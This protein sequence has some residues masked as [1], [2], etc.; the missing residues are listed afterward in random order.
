[1]TKTLFDPLQLHAPW[2]Q[3]LAACGARQNTALYEV[4]ESQRSYLA[5]AL[6]AHTGKQVLYVAPSE[7][8]ATRAAEDCAQLLGGA[9]ALL[10][11]PDVQF[12]RAISGRD[13]S[14]HRLQVIDRVRQGKVQVLCVSAESLLTRFMPAN[15]FDQA[16]LELKEG[17]EQDPLALIAHL[18]R[19]GY[20]RVPMVEAKGQCALLGD[21]LN[22]FPPESDEPLRIEFFDTIIDSIRSFDVL[23][24]RSTG[25]TELVRIGPATE[26][27]IAEEHRA[28]AA[29]QMQAAIQQASASLPKAQQRY[30]SL[31][32]GEQEAFSPTSLGG[33]RMLRDVEQLE[34]TGSFPNM[35]MWA[36]IVLPTTNTL[37]DLLHDPVVVIDSPDRVFQRLDERLQGFAEDLQ[38]AL[39]RE[40]AVP[41]QQHLL[42]PVDEVR[43]RLEKQPVVTMQELLRGMGGLQPALT[44][45]LQGQGSSQYQARYADL[46]LQIKQWM[47]DGWYIALL[48]SGQARAERMQR[49]LAE[50][51]VPLTLPTTSDGLL[52]LRAGQPALLSLGYSRG[53]IMPDAGL[54][55]ITD[56]DVFGSNRKKSRRRQSA[57]EKIDA[58][59][60]LS[61]GD[62]VVHEHHGVGIYRGTVRLQSEGTWRDY[63]FIQY[64]DN[65]KLYVPLDQF[66]RV[67]KYVGAGDAAPALNDLGTGDWAR[68]KKK[69]KSGLQRLAFDLVQL[70]AQRQ[71]EQGHVF[72]AQQAFEQQFSDNFEYE[73]TP[74]Q[75]QAV[76]EVLRDMERPINMDRLLCGDVGYGKTEVAM[77]AAFRAVSNSRQ[78]AFLAPTTILVQQH[79][80]TLTK[81]FEGFPV[82]MDFVSR[83]RSPRQN[84]ETLLKAA[85]GELDILIGTHR[86]L[87]KDVTF[88]NLGLLVVDEEQ[89]FGVAHKEGI[90]NLKRKVDVLTLSATPI[91]R[92]L[93]M[94]MV[95][96]RDM[97]LL[98]TPPEERLPVQTYVVEYSDAL[99]RDAILR[100]TARK[101]QVFVLH[102]RVADIDLYASRLR[103][104]VPEVRIA[105]AHGQMKE[106]ALE[107][108]MMDFVAGHYD[109]LLCTTIIENGIDIQR[110]NTLIVLDADRFGL[111]QLYQLRGRVGRGANLGYAYFTVRAGR[112]ITETAE[113]R[114]AAIKEFTEFGSGFRIA[115]RDLS[116]RGAGNMLGSEQSG[117][118]SAVGYD[119]YCKLI[120]EAVREAK[121]DFSGQRESDLETRVELHVN[122]FLPER[123]VPGQMQRMEIYKRISSI[124]TD[125]DRSDLLDEL[126]DR[127]GEPDEPVTNLMDVAYLRSLANR[128]GA[129]FVTY[130]ND[131]L[132][133]RLNTQY[134]I[135]PSLLYKAMVT[136]DPRLGMQTG[137]RNF[138]LLNLVGYEEVE[139]LKEGVCVLSHL[140]STIEALQA[141]QPVTA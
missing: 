39:T 140:L 139:A 32:P 16:C 69:V 93:H 132:K 45:R 2:Q 135:D 111:S 88:K 124:R 92:T 9:A 103:Q 8:A 14:W 108:V 96:V 59:T 112:M 138:L 34:E 27:F 120:E 101:G 44:L 13:N 89:R 25:R 91:P 56:A 106:G 86:L 121:G 94:S 53:F 131:A 109:L 19:I 102:N 119:L 115:L 55:L 57:G 43:D 85:R 133:L 35:S 33:S 67:Q 70:Y 113:K 6:A 77:R 76:A 117:Q 104:L 123:Y 38:L 130:Q 125:E 61:E 31:E 3:M 137:K 26:Y 29:Q 127:F 79:Y 12:L 68:Q 54:A 24:Q 72:P 84:K 62:Y 28:E 129:E 21:I 46:A 50:F 83:F 126:I 10:P 58:F 18:I 98:E 73:L 87:S 97:S 100:E 128:I 1:M 78:V 5:A 134:V 23:T 71:S 47:Q 65:D 80:R 75:Q 107:D 105:V 7:Q 63:L 4:T 42:Y 95:G 116:I 118:V 64:R 74:D 48:C 37:V 20:E 11:T 114:L 49:M 40:E 66:E 122:A 41:A 30:G 99:I 17:E 15:D 110:A 90:K 141:E 60:D 52:T 136:S 22:V 36:Q 51:G 81:R 82:S